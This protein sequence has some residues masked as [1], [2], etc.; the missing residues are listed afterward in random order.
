MPTKPRSHIDDRIELQ[1]IPDSDR[2]QFDRLASAV[3]RVLV[4]NSMRRGS[5]PDNHN[6][7]FVRRP[8]GEGE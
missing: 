3:A 5:E 7:T 6:A 8:H 4:K 2:D 1:Q